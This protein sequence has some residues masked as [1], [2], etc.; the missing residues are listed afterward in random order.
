MAPLPGRVLELS[1]TAVVLRENV[2]PEI[3][4][5]A[6]LS[7]CWGPEGPAIQLKKSTAAVLRA[8]VPLASLRKTFLETVKVCLKLGISYLWIDALCE[9]RNIVRGFLITGRL[10]VAL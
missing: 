3:Q 4:R 2:K 8:G 5:Y 10:T 6:C 7:H 1:D 9:Y